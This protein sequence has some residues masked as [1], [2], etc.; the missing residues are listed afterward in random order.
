[1]GFRNPLTTLSASQITSGTLPAGVVLPASQV[2]AGALDLLVIARALADGTVT[3]PAIAAGAVTAAKIAADTITAAQIAAGA[4]GVVEL[5]AGAVTA[6]KI[7]ARAIT[8]DKLTV[9]VLGTNRLANAEFES[10]GAP[11]PMP[12]WYGT[13]PGWSFVVGTSG[14]NS[15]F[16]YS[17]GHT[18]HAGQGLAIVKNGGIDASGDTLLSDWAPVSP[19]RQ[20]LTSFAVRSDAGFALRTLISIQWS[21]NGVDVLSGV[22]LLWADA[23]YNIWSLPAIPVTTAPPGANYA[24]VTVLNQGRFVGYDPDPSYTDCLLLIDSAALI[25]IGTPAV[26]V[27]PA[28]IRMWDRFGAETITLNGETAVLG[29]GVL[30]ALSGAKVYGDLDVTGDTILAGGVHTYVVNS[31]TTLVAAAA[32]ITTSGANTFLSP[33]GEI[34]R[35]SSLRRYKLD[36]E[37]IGVHPELL[38]LLAMTWRDRAELA[39]DPGTSHRVPGFVAED[40][41]A[42]SA[43]HGGSLEP[44][45]TRDENGALQGLAYDRIAAYLLPIVA[46]L[47]DRVRHLEGSTR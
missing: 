27:T 12:G 20:Y 15:V 5:A 19:G 41:Q 34:Q 35:V 7:A 44:L 31:D 39:A 36:R 4:I 46:E 9:G 47:R 26:E 13:S 45:L 42:V 30:I 14:G 18:A 1:M 28:G 38:D 23:P 8:A 11:L 37:P 17:M 2:G 40:V 16:E 25:E 21:T 10:T 29:A 43:A 33:A 6:D 22:G 24:R 32:P 3:G